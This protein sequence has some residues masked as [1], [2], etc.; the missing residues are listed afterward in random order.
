[1]ERIQYTNLSYCI[2]SKIHLYS[3]RYHRISWY[4]LDHIICNV[5]CKKLNNLEVYM[6][7][8]LDHS[9]YH[10]FGNLLRSNPH[11]RQFGK[12]LFQNYMWKELCM[13]RIYHQR[14]CI[15]KL[16]IDKFR[17]CSCNILSCIEYIYKISHNFDNEDLLF[18]IVHLFLA[19]I[20]INS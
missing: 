6:Y 5:L 18:G 14:N 3:H 13:T 15:Q 7:Y 11:I 10:I 19:W 16:I 20:L 8:I 1:M 12:F 17:S 2:Y 4:N 9:L